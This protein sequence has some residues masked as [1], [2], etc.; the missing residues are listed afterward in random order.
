MENSIVAFIVTDVICFAVVF[1][2]FLRESVGFVVESL[3][4]LLKRKP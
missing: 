1:Y 4:S 3:E 2:F